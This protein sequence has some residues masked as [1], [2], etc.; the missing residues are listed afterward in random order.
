MSHPSFPRNAQ[1]LQPTNQPARQAGSQAARQPANQPANPQKFQ[2][3]KRLLVF[4]RVR[5]PAGIIGAEL[6]Q[7]P[8]PWLLSEMQRRSCYASCVQ[9]CVYVCVCV[10]VCVCVPSCQ[11]N[12]KLSEG[13]WMSVLV[14]KRVHVYYH[15]VGR[16]EQ[17]LDRC[18][19]EFCLP[20][21]DVASVAKGYKS[22][23]TLLSPFQAR[24][25]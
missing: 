23:A 17:D 11:K 7:A 14:G 9:K 6:W 20:R 16:F 18:L 8:L 25:G 2:A 4:S 3:E 1:K 10:C 24:S 5:A 12:W 13:L 19:S 22:Q 21:K 15:P